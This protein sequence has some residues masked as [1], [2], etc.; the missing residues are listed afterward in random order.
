V[1]AKVQPSI[2][3]AEGLGVGFAVGIEELFAA[4]LP[5]LLYFR[6]GDE[7]PLRLL[8]SPDEV[9]QAGHGFEA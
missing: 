8:Q 9:V 4:F 2:L 1:I 6:R 5:R 7:G 3:L